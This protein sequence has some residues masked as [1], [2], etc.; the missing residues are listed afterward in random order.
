[1]TRADREHRRLYE[2]LETLAAQ[3]DGELPE[4]EL[5]KR[6][7]LTAR[8][9]EEFSR[10]RYIKTRYRGAIGAGFIAWSVTDAGREML[11]AAREIARGARR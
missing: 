9:L 10:S 3:L 7:D 2:L 11:A 5:A 4:I 6:C 8:E 1:M